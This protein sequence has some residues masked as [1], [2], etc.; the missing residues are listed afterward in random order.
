MR[1]RIIHR[2]YIS[3]DRLPH[4]SPRSST[5]L[6]VPLNQHGLPAGNSVTTNG[7]PL[8][9]KTRTV[10]L[11]PGDQVMCGG[12]RRTI[13]GIEAMTS[14]WLTEEE[15]AACDFNAGYI[16]R[17]TDRRSEPSRPLEWNAVRLLGGP[18]KKFAS[19]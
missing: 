9:P 12:R 16:Y 5:G 7:L 13:V 15:A 3:L 19:S 1:Y 8:P 4:E 17:P 2:I 11:R 18:K 6:C 14:A 10:D